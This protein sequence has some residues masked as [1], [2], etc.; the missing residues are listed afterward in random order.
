MVDENKNV[1]S[2]T[3]EVPIEEE[4]V[5]REIDETL[6]RLRKEVAIP[7]FRPG[8]VP[9]QVIAARIGKGWQTKI[10]VPLMHCVKPCIVRGPHPLSLLNDTL[11]SLQ[12]YLPL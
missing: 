8:K 11:T 10:F 5:T 2:M 12:V 4:E 6:K 9:I 3:V 1:N 7:G